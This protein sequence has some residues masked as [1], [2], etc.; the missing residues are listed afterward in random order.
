VSADS[1]AEMPSFKHALLF[2]TTQAVP[3]AHAKAS[4]EAEN[5]MQ[6]TELSSRSIP[7]VPASETL[8]LQ[9]RQHQTSSTVVAR[10]NS[11][12]V[13]GQRSYCQVGEAVLCPGSTNIWCQGQECC[14]GQDGGPNFPCPSAPEG[15]GL[16][17]CQNTEKVYDCTVG[18][19]CQ[20]GDVVQ[21]PGS[22]VWCFG[23]ECCPGANGEPNFPCPSAP[24]GWAEGM[25]QE[26][27]KAYDCTSGYCQV[28]D[29]V[30][31]PGSPDVW[32]QGQECCPGVDGA[33]NFPCPSAPHG[34]GQNA[35]QSTAKAYDCTSSFQ[36]SVGE[37]VQC[38]G[39]G[40]WCSGEECCPGA[41]GEDNF[42]CPSAPSGWG[43][44][45]CQS[46][47]KKWDCTLPPHPL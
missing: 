17:A 3:Q 25:C 2:S 29:T 45:S 4:V 33:D 31:C 43:S 11:T 14:P 18:W 30:Q 42:P 35:C 34:W 20:A 37:N 32:C 46:T 15:W 26:T 41:E 21:C 38:P 10:A 28:G 9:T 8:L 40:V 7:S 1:A 13:M 27:T 12:S 5:C 6:T 39:S 47:S 44:G 22:G 23:E 24:E 36:C 19:Q 16:S